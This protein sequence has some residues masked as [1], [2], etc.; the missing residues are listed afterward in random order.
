MAVLNNRGIGSL[1]GKPATHPIYPRGPT[2][3]VYVILA[4]T[5]RAWQSG[6][7]L[8]QLRHHID[9]AHAAADL[10]PKLDQ[11]GIYGPSGSPSIDW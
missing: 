6:R 3:D 7:Q 4:R 1:S 5:H 11:L 10:G 2:T 8:G 9:A